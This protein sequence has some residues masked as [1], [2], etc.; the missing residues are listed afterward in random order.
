MRKRAL[1]TDDCSCW[2]T[3]VMIPTSTIHC[4]VKHTAAMADALDARVTEPTTR[5]VM[6]M[7]E[8][9]PSMR[10]VRADPSVSVRAVATRAP[11]P[12]FAR[13]VTLPSREEEEE[14]E[15][16]CAHHDDETAESGRVQL[17]WGWNTLRLERETPPVEEALELRYAVMLSCCGDHVTQGTSLPSV[18]Q[19]PGASYA[20]HIVK[21]GTNPNACMTP[22]PGFPPL[23]D[24]TTADNND[25]WVLVRCYDRASVAGF[26]PHE[27][28]RIDAHAGSR[29][30]SHCRRP[31]IAVTG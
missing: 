22:H 27:H 9:V 29:T 5:R 31:S 19:A 2:G 23:A 4:S 7:F 30:D 16:A 24:R 26:R 8:V 12:C 21:P 28:H 17:A 6:C 3:S 11:P 25:V 18:D 1:L 10:D 20:R 14:E 15:E 13:V